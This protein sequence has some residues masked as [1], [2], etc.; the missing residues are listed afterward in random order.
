MKNIKKLAVLSLALVMSIA[1]LGGITAFAKA[2][3]KPTKVSIYSP[4]KNIY[5]YDEFELKARITPANAEDDYLKWSIVK[6]SDVIRFDDNDR[7]GDDAE[8]KAI[9]AGTAK[10][11]CQ[12]KG[13]T[14]KYYK[15]V[16]VKKGSGEISAMGS[17]SRTYKVGKEFELKVKEGSG[18]DDN[19][20]KWTISDRSVVVFD[21]DDRYGDDMDFKARKS[22]TTK[23]TCTNTVNN[24]K[25]TYTIKVTGKETSDNKIYIVGKKTKTV[26]V[27]D[28][29]DLEVKKGSGVK[30]KNLRWSIKNTKIIRFDDD[31]KWDDEVEF[32]A[33]RTGKTTV[34]CTNKATNQKITY[35]IKVVSEYDNDDD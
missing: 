10:V 7:T 24:S 27:G 29:F 16:T 5:I 2:N 3:V 6:G 22:G 33:I 35:T 9:K 31:D 19:K 23:I 12:I 26:E 15:T 8:F 28:D 20:L 34:T 25:V 30:D 32:E 18:V 4:K 13:T 14:K 17:T 11:C 1:C 21:D